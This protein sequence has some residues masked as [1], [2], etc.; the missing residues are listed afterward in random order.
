MPV[1]QSSITKENVDSLKKR[2]E[3][4]THG[5]VT[6]KPLP[7]DGK[8]LVADWNGFI[9]CLDATSGKLIYEKQIYKP[10]KGSTIIRS[11]PLLKLLFGEPIPYM[12]NGFAGTG[13]LSDGV[14]YLASVGGKEGS[15]L[16]NGAAG[17]LYAIHPEDGT[18]LWEH[19]LAEEQ[20][21]GSLA[22]PVCSGQFLYV[23]LCSVDEVASVTYKLHLKRFTPQCVGEVFCFN[24]NSGKLIWRR[25]TNEIIP[26]DDRNAK[27]AGV[28][29]GL[30]VDAQSNS[31]FFA[32]GNNYGRPASKSSD[33]VFCVNSFDGSFKWYFQALSDDAWLPLKR[34]G[35]DYDFGSTPIPFPCRE[36]QSGT[37]VAAG[38]KDGFLYTFDSVSAKLLWKADCHPRAVPDDGIRSNITYENGRIIV[39]CKN[40]NPKNTISVVCVNAD[41]GNLIWDTIESGLNSM[42]TGFITN[43]LY[44]MSNYDGEIYALSTENAER[45]WTGHSN[46]SSFG[47]D[48]LLWNNRVYSGFGV[49]LLYGGKSYRCGVTCF[50]F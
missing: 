11:L 23:G 31:L 34:D 20:Y 45:F 16:S 50:G 41:S 32:T 24:K 40:K 46:K 3:F 43:G 38:N 9:Y 14:W 33:A 17:R 10:P 25:K 5:N 4:E 19:A 30:S 37:A 44:F 26:G 8:L 21:S 36:A 48:L 7:H 29:G 22:V 28:W 39:W 1:Y 13:C 2:W 49:P 12:W 15:A 6:A 27:G 18:V 47:S 42:T 35:P